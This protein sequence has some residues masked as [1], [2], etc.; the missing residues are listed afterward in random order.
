MRSKEPRSMT[1]QAQRGVTL[2]ELMVVVAIVGILGAIAVPAYRNYVIRSNRTDA[3]TALLQV[4]TAEE[5][6][7]LDN[8]AYTG[9][10]TVAPPGGLGLTGNSDAGKYAVTVV[11]NDAGGQTYTATAAPV[12]GK[13]QD[14]DTGCASFSL[15]DSGIR[16]V[17]GTKPVTECWR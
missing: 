2:M 5:K 7:Y 3:K 8:N 1:R 14:K 12:A 4:Q 15:T 16:T 17:T 13:G 9:A 10:V 11:L 6:F